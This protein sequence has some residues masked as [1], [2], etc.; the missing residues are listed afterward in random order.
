MKKINYLFL[1]ISVIAI[2]SC[3]KND[4]EGDKD[5]NAE[6]PI[7]ISTTF[8]HK[9]IIEDYTASWCGWC[10]SIIGAIDKYSSNKNFIPIAIHS[11][12]EMKFS[13]TGVLM[14]QFS[15]D[16]Y[17]TAIIN[18]IASKK[19]HGQDPSR[20]IKEKA[21]I[22]IGIKT[23]I[24]EK[25]AKIDLKLNFDKEFEF[26]TALKVTVMLLEDDIIANQSNYL[27]GDARYRDSKF[28]SLSNPVKDFHHNHV[29]REIPT[30]IQGD[31]IPD[32]FVKNCSEYMKSYTIDISAYK[33]D[34]C[35][36][37]AFVEQDD[38]SLSLGVL[39]AQIVKLGEKIF[40]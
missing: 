19:W 22:S 29:L 40:Y 35:H 31:L 38:R 30:D 25:E 24:E 17:P 13:K 37:V 28:Y 1:L 39:N 11:N 16:G 33:A 34:K 15:V 36:I 2:F 26:T 27:S 5:E 21:P 20:Y 8:V 14:T 3:S 23:S 9:I 4:F 6:K 10:P 18:R 12:D 7:D 32:E